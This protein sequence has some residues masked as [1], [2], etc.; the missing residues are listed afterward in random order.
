[1]IARLIVAAALFLLP[2]RSGD[3]WSGADKFLARQEPPLVSYRAR[4]RLLASNERRHVSGWMDAV[5]ELG[6]GK[7]FRFQI[8]AEGGSAFIRNRVLRRS[9]GGNDSGT[10]LT[11]RAGPH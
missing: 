11:S 6:P 8:A 7:A 1:M 9:S 3:E 4:R 2:V 5:T 10:N